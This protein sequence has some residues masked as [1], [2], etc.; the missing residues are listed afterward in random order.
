M[1]NE[2]SAAETPAP[3]S[4]I[5]RLRRGTAIVFLGSVLGYGINYLATPLLGRLVTPEAFGLFSATL[6]LA[7]LFTGVSTMRLEVFAASVASAAHQ[8]N[9]RMLALLLA[10]ATSAL[11]L[12]G[13]LVAWTVAGSS[14]LWMMA[15]PMVF[16]G[17]LQLVATARYS[18]ARAY[19][20][21]GVGNLIQGGGTAVAQLGLATLS[22]SALALTGGFLLARVHWFLALRGHGRTRLPLRGT[23]RRARS[24]ARPAGASAFLNS[25]G[26]QAPVLLVTALFGAAGAGVFA[27]AVRLLVGPLAILAQ[28]VGSTTMGEIGRMSAARDP[29][30]PRTVDALIR[31]LGVLMLIPC[32]LTAVLAPRLVPFA[33]GPGWDQVG[34]V[35]Q[36]LAIGAFAQAVGSPLTQILNLTHRS[37]LMLSWD[38]ARLAT[39]M[40]TF[41]AVP[42]L[43]GGVVLVSMVYSAVM[44]V[45]YTAALIMVRRACRARVAES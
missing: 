21:M 4:T 12:L 20:A 9:A 6:A 3:S 11:V 28:A 43:G 14:P 30:L 24:F 42:L 35:I 25:A 36:V 31:Q 39:I 37:G 41:V 2:P 13:A 26:G 23:W 5:S 17:S 44:V 1:V 34:T 32:A 22:P 18:V 38:T 29:E 10:A 45:L 16:M 7:S 19:P 15:A 33:L 27:M 40:I 8:H